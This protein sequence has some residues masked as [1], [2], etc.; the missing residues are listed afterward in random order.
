MQEEDPMDVPTTVIMLPELRLV[1]SRAEPFP[2]GIPAAW[3]RLE[4][5]LR[6]LKGRKFYGLTFR[7][8]DLPVYYAGLEPRDEAEVARLGL[9][10][11][12]VRGGPYARAR[13]LSWGDQPDQ[14]GEVIAAMQ[15]RYGSDPTRPTIEYYR[16]QRELHLLVPVPV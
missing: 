7:E 12:V 2:D 13:L 1:V 6:A 15:R 14:I 11:L 4:A 3:E 16:G 10:L 5:P 8:G 9:P